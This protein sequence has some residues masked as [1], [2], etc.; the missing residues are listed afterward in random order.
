MAYNKKKNVDNLCVRKA[1]FSILNSDEL[2]KLSRLK[3]ITLKYD[4]Q[5]GKFNK[6]IIYKAFSKLNKIILFDAFISY[7]KKDDNIIRPYVNLYI[8]TI[9][10]DYIKFIYKDSIFN[11]L[12]NLKIEDIKSIEE[13]VINLF[14]IQ[15]KTYKERDYDNLMSF[16]KLNENSSYKDKVKA[17]HN[18]VSERMTIPGFY[19]WL[20]VMYGIKPFINYLGKL[21]VIDNNAVVDKVFFIYPDRN[22]P[23]DRSE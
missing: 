6:S 15:N 2:K 18:Y 9:V 22:D 16:Y 10:L 17:L 7:K 3:Y 8:P 12:D 4:F 5:T 23:N 14:K 1:N 21:S 13:N 11:D 20:A 19:F